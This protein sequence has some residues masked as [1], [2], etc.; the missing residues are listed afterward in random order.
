MDVAFMG[1]RKEFHATLILH[2]YFEEVACQVI[3]IKL[4]T[5]QLQL[6]K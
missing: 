2:S 4:A 6:Q 1:M 5:F 3:A